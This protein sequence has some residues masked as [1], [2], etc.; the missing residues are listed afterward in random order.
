M[1]PEGPVQSDEPPNRIILEARLPK[2]PSVS[3]CGLQLVKVRLVSVI[4]GRGDDAGDP[5]VI[6]TL[7][8]VGVLAE[9]SLIETGFR[10]LVTWSVDFPD[11]VR[12]PVSMSG[13]H[14]LEFTV[15]EALS[16]ASA[17]YYA[18]V[19]SV[20][21]LYP[22]VRQLVDELTVKSLGRNVMIRPLDVPQFVTGRTRQWAQRHKINQSEGASGDDR[23]DGQ[24]TS[25]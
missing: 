2:P 22:Y 9:G 16:Q 23:S 1:T 13:K 5:P 20:V 11:G 3:E 17:E 12:S 15:K 19:N 14:E 6:A 18:E 21:L 7:N 4:L 10:A 25:E 8:C 24:D